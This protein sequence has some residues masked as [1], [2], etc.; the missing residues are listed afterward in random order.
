MCDW[1]LDLQAYENSTFLLSLQ[2]FVIRH[3]QQQ[4]Q[5]RLIEVDT[6]NCSESQQLRGKQSVFVVAGNWFGLNRYFR[7][8]IGSSPCYLS[9]ALRRMDAFFDKIQS[10]PSWPY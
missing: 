5:F 8:G 9:A 3:L 6:L 2:E 7:V 4:Y 1:N 10:K